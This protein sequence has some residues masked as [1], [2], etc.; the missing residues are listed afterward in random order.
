[1]ARDVVAERYVEAVEVGAERVG[2]VHLAEVCCEFDRVRRNG[3]RIRVVED[4]EVVL[5]EHERRGRFDA[6]DAE[7]FA[8]EVGEHADIPAGGVAGG[9]EV[10]ASQ[11]RDPAADLPRR[12]IHFDAVVP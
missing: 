6:D 11:R 1:M 12:H 9:I 7:A 4:V 8:G 2:G 5:R 10:P 3:D